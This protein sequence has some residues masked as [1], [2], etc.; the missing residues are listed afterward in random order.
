MLLP[1]DLERFW[2]DN[3]IA[4]RDPFCADNPQAP[5]T[6]TTS[7]GCLWEELGLAPDPRYYTNAEVHVRLNRRYND[8]AE[9]IVGRRIL[10]EMFVPPERQLPRPKRIEEILGSQIVT[11]PGSEEIGGAD[12]VV[13]SIH[14][15]GEL[16]ARL[17]Y[18]ES[19]DWTE[20]V[21]PPGF[22]AALERLREDYGQY[23]QLGGG[24]RGPVTAAM[25]LCGVE[26]VILWLVDYPDVMAR[27]RDL[28]ARKIVEL[29]TLLRQATD[30]PMR[31]FSFADDNCALLNARLYECF[32][33]PILQHVFAVF[34]PDAKDYRYQHSD[35]EM[36]HLLP[37]LARCQL[38]GCN[39]GPT[40]RPDAIRAAMPRTVIYGQ[41]PPFT[42]SRGAPQE[43]AEAV[44]RDIKAVGYDGGLVVD[45]AGSVNPGSKLEGLRA[46]MH[47]I[48]TLGQYR[49]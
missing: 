15:I 8:K 47:A 39:L 25:S 11:V 12:W 43:I 23:P 46:A 6:L 37:L 7:E 45:T 17:E 27:F 42:F 35:S 49:P 1:V 33:L 9:E 19:L 14:T 28:L 26:N 2:R 21:F 44:A 38:H 10:P 29:C 40:V 48:Q 16:E 32:G 24:I 31:G 30:A 13:E 3:A 4:L 41:L 22:F 36:S 5:M 18:V 34:C 20:T